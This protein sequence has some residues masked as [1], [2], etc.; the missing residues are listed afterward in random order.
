MTDLTPVASLDP[1]VQLETTDRALGGTGNPM[2][3]QAQAL[4]NRDAFRAQEILARVAA[5]D[6]ADDADPL[7]G[8][9][10]VGH[11]GRFVRDR[12]DDQIFVTDY[13]VVPGEPDSTAGVMNAWTAATLSGKELVFP[14]GVYNGAWGNLANPELV[15]RCLGEVELHNTGAGVA[16]TL[17]AGASNW[18]QFRIEGS[19]IVSGNALSTDGVHFQGLHHSKLDIRVKDVP[20]TAFVGNFGVLSSYRLVCSVNEQAF[21]ITPTKGIELDERGAGEF[22]ADCDFYLMIE[23]VDGIG[24]DLLSVQGCR[25]YG[26]SEGNT[27]RGIRDTADCR[28]NTW[29]EFWCEAN[30]ANDMELYGIGNRFNNC[31]A[32]SSAVT[33]N[34]EL[35]SAQG[36]VFSGGFIRC[37]NR[38]A[39]SFDTLFENCGTSDNASLGFK[40][41]GTYRL[42]N[43][44]RED[45]SGVL[46]SRY[47]DVLGNSGTFSPTIIGTGG[48]AAHTYSAQVGYYHIA[49]GR[50]YYEILVGITT[51]DGGM[52]GNVSI[53]GLPI[54]SR[55][56]ANRM[57]GVSFANYTLV[58]TTAARPHLTGRLLPNTQAIQL[59]INGPAAGPV[60]IASADIV[61]GSSLTL[62]GSYPL[63][64]TI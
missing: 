46:T 2:N 41:T 18:Y 48:T 38:Q 39:A 52:T 17:S 64:A 36:T 29:N 26:T 4:L 62:S 30:G 47:S 53:G 51:K 34:V 44:W 11:R 58:T 7:K 31:R 57:S 20:G 50:L 45:V 32:L 61:N 19:L 55:N 35:V 16:L 60:Q 8:S 5:V 28:Y 22:F 3:R 63:P 43:C 40:G 25:L 12:L 27:N 37:V 13:M 14:A 23:G 54:L 42:I 24:V 9:G 21:A 10:Q 1:V 15:I 56:D 59:F 6:L 49:G 33:N